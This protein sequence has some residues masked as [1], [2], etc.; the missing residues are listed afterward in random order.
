MLVSNYRHDRWVVAGFLNAVQVKLDQSLPGLN[1][2]TFLAENLPQIKL[3][4]EG[5][6]Y[7]AWLDLSSIT[8][9]SAEFSSVYGGNGASFI[10]LNLAY[11]RVQ[12]KDALQRLQDFLTEE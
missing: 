8:N 4:S 11:P 6:T 10:R 3:A 7:L 12:I 9:D 1:Q 2:V 5:A